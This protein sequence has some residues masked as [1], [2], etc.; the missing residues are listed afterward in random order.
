VAQRHARQEQSDGVLRLDGKTV[1]QLHWESA[2][3]NMK[4]LITKKWT[5][6][7]NRYTTAKECEPAPQSLFG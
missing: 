4:E 5:L 2:V 3:Q 1:H 7:S 6:S